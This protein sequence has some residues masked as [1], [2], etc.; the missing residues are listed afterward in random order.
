MEKVPRADEW[1]PGGIALAD[2]DA[3]KNASMIFQERYE[4]MSKI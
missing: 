2:L 3:R 1:L 4:K